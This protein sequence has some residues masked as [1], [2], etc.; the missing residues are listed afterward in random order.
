MARFNPNAM[1]GPLERL[2]NSGIRYS[3]VIDVGCADGHLFLLL[4]SLG[5]KPH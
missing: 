5:L 1:L 2:H 3:T 4:Q